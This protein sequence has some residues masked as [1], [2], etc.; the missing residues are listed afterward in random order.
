M[1]HKL[2]TRLARPSEAR[3]GTWAAE[4]WRAVRH[5]KSS[6][7]A[8]LLGG[9]LAVVALLASFNSLSFAFF[10]S[11]VHEATIRHNQL[12]LR[13][14]VN[15]YENHFRY[16]QSEAVR[17]YFDE[18]VDSLRRT[19][20]NSNYAQ[21]LELTG[22]IKT[23]VANELL[24]M[25]NLVVYFKKNDFAI[26]R[27]GSDKADTLFAKSY[28]SQAYDAAFWQR[29]FDGKE[30]LAVYPASEFVKGNAGTEKLVRGT[31]LPVVMRNRIAPDTVVA[32]FLD[33]GKLYGA[34]RYFDSDLFYIW[35]ERNGIVFHNVRDPSVQLP[36]AFE[37]GASFVKKGDYYYFYGKG[38]TTGLTYVSVVPNDK[39]AAQVSRLQTVLVVLLVAAVAASA[40]FSL[41]VAMRLHS[42]L[43][44][45]VSSMQSSVPVR[46]IRSG[47]SEFKLIRARLN[48]LLEQSRHTD[49]DLR[50]KNDLLRRFGYLSKLKSIEG[51]M[52][53][54]ADVRAR[55]D[56]ANPNYMIVYHLAFTP[57]FQR[58]GGTGRK[59]AAAA[60]KQ[61]IELHTETFSRESITLQI[62]KDYVLSLVFDDPPAQTMLEALNRLKPIFDRDKDAC[63]VTIAVHPQWKQPA[64]FTEA[65]EK[66]R[67]MV[68]QR[69]PKDETQLV[70]EYRP[71]SYAV[72]FSGSLEKEF[73]SHL[74]AGNANHLID[75]AGRMLDAMEAKGASAHQFSQIAKELAGKVTRSLIEKHIDIPPDFELQAVHGHIDGCL[76]HAHYR[77]FMNE[78][79]RR[80]AE[81]VAERQ[82]EQDGVVGA[83]K[84]LI[85]NHY[86]EDLSLEFIADR[87]NMSKGYLSNYFKEKTGV[88][89]VLY[90]NE[91]RIGK[92]I[93][94]LRNTNARIRDVALLV[95]YENVNS[96][97]RMFKRMTGYTP[98]EYRK[99]LNCGSVE[100]ND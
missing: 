27:D 69:L 3:D 16:V 62:E 33:A 64:D 26:D 82:A 95:G 19:A 28:R 9:F 90:V 30:A 15:S 12:T 51:N 68:R 31:F 36:T 72:F 89:F 67:S 86:G 98:R 60:I 48:D 46:P 21:V 71:D 49:A 79:A 57:E 43:R 99:N 4:L 13:H 8:K 35:D 78:F 70:T 87:L 10:T 83:V 41:F 52:K 18:R 22:A 81:L 55:V 53:E 5:G 38:E 59:R 32:A 14:T 11:N 56:S 92:A 93:D 94:L 17:L 29:Q 91:Y 61:Y 24:Q 42:P 2:A 66:T 63:I 20:D 76:T 7:F 85:A 39:V 25:D 50:R 80:A 45:I 100:P 74:Q 77:A 23:L 73:M 37:E 1:P 44:A 47:V 84:Q 40:A 6:L 88:N 65:Y 58:S 34:Y 75:V 54:Y 97:I 96:F